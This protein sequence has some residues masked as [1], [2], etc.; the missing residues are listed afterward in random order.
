[1]AVPDL[2]YPQ[3]IIIVLYYILL[4]LSAHH[5]RIAHYY[6]N[7]QQNNVHHLYPAVDDEPLPIEVSDVSTVKEDETDVN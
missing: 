5:Y 3:D 4:S 6:E 1:M 2:A 7:Q